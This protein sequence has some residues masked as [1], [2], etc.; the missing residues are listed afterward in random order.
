MNSTATRLFP[1]YWASRH[2]RA[3]RPPFEMLLD[4]SP[5]GLSLVSTTAFSEHV[6]AVMFSPWQCPSPRNLVLQLQESP[7]AKA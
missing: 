1:F 4:F 7:I 5:A 2:P 3:F 6:K